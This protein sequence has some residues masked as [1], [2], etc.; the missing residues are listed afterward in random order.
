VLLGRAGWMPRAFVAIS[1]AG[2]LA[3]ALANPD[4]WIAERNLQRGGQLDEHYLR[5]LSADAAPALGALA[6][7]PAGGDGAA[8]WNLARARARAAA[9][10]GD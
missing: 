8:G 6:V 1:A 7:C 3:F 2:A 5:S 9:C 4:G 10:P